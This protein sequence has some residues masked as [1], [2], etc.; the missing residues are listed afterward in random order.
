M[1]VAELQIDGVERVE[2]LS[3]RLTGADAPEVRGANIVASFDCALAGLR[4]RGCILLA[5]REGFEVRPPKASSLAGSVEFHSRSVLKSVIYAA[6]T[7]YR[8]MRRCGQ[9]S[10]G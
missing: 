2:I 7:R 4:L 5:H 6:K 8:E 9:N 3:M 1:S 10:W